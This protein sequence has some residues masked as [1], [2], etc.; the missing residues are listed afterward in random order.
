M[1]KFLIGLMAAA[2][3]FSAAAEH[4]SSTESEVRAAVKAFNGAYEENDVGT[5]F[6]YYIDHATL[7]FFG[8]RQ[9][10][11]AYHEQW[12]AMVDAGGGV[13]K[14]ELSDVRVQVLP[15]GNVAVATY[16]IDNESRSP[17]GDTSA[18]KAFETDVWLKTDGGWKIVSLHYTEIP[19]AD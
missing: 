17:D 6:S 16:F 5:Y 4:H 13:E 7:Y 12:Q 1:N 14:N 11:S 9:D 15:G 10:V 2:I 8:E 19:P 3:T 18:A